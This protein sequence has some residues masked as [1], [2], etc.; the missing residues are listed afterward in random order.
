MD[1]V[2]MEDLI[3]AE[4]FF[5]RSE[6]LSLIFRL[7]ALGTAIGLMATVGVFFVLLRFAA[8]P[9][10]VPFCFWLRATAWR[11]ITFPC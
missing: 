3:A 8:G 4:S 10:L 1:L 9:I 7:L 11:A 2:M 6:T 5:F